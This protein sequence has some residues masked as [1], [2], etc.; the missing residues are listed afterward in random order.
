M[1]TWETTGKVAIYAIAETRERRI[2]SS[3]KN[4]PR[5]DVWDTSPGCSIRQLL[6]ASTSLIALSIWRTIRKYHYGIA[7]KVSAS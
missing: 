3:A 6:H 1:I 4:T 2:P 5:L 7:S